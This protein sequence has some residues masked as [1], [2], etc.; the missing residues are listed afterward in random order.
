MNTETSRADWKL[1]AAKLKIVKCAI[2]SKGLQCARTNQ[3]LHPFYPRNA[4]GRHVVLS[5]L[6]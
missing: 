3:T 6:Q 5:T 1:L 2:V 4:Q